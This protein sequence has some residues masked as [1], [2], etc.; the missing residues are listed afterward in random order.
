MKGLQQDGEESL[1]RKRK[2]ENEADGQPLSK[3][4]ATPSEAAPSS[5]AHT[6]LGDDDGEDLNDLD[7]LAG[8]DDDEID[9]SSVKDV[10]VG[11][12]DKVH[13]S[14]NKWKVNLKDCVVTIKGR[15]YLLKKATGDMSF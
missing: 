3:V 10:I 9:E 7:D 14:K 15:D 8:V 6:S 5:A 11:M 4:T 2:A 1:I 13:R 12:F